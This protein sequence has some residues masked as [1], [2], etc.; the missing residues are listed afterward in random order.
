MKRKGSLLAIILL[1]MALLTACGGDDD[2]S[3]SSESAS[4]NSNY[5]GTIA[6]T[7]GGANM[8]AASS[9]LDT[10]SRS[11]DTGD[12]DDYH[13]SPKNSNTSN[14]NEQANRKII[15]T[16]D[17]TIQTG[18]KT[19]IETIMAAASE[20]CNELGGYE[21]SR[22]IDGYRKYYG[23]ITLRVPK[24]N[25]DEFLEFINDSNLV[26]TKLNDTSEDVTLKYTDVDSRLGSAKRQQKKYEEYAEKAENMD[27]LLRIE[28][29]LD[30]VTAD[31]ESYQSQMN[32]LNN[33]IDY[34]TVRL[35]IESKEKVAYSSNSFSEQFA[36]NMYGFGE[37]LADIVTGM[38][39]AAIVVIL[40]AIGFIPA[41]IIFIFTLRFA[42]RFKFKDLVNKFR[43][44]RNRGYVQSRGDTPDQRD[45][46]DIQGPDKQ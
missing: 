16:V 5:D 15:R 45:I 21:E 42:F 30:S 31:L 4:I 29:R 2:R 1:S 18:T 3:Y 6:S 34:C 10:S 38:I 41:I 20:K 25:T 24:S 40:A 14:T 22:S 37:D 19:D 33:Q 43:T 44:R 46:R 36:E 12:S 17:M 9:G 27:D 23:D 11:A 35:D 26:I 39:S 32:T 28:E 7:F 8:T 13:K